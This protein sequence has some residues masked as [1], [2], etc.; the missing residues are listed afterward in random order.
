MHGPGNINF[1]RWVIYRIKENL[2]L[3]EVGA[4]TYTFCFQEVFQQILEV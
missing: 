1:T 3:E 4:G 2:I